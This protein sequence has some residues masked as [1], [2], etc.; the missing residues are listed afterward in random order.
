MAKVSFTKLGLKSN[1]DI[2]TM[3]WNDQEIEV[4]Q[5]LPINDKLTLISNVLN[6]CSE[7]EKFYN[8]GKFE[9]YF[10]LEV[11][12]NYTNISP[13][14]KQKEDACKLYDAFVSSGL[15]YEILNNLNEDDVAF[16]YEVALDSIKAIYAYSNS[17]MGILDAVTTDYKGLDLDANGIYNNLADPQNME[18]LKGIMTRLG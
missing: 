17:A 14:E 18:L 12:Y 9:L 8:M 13:T 1:K 2:K 3:I 11:I 7:E 4:K 5:Y 15:Y 10:T 6:H 16:L